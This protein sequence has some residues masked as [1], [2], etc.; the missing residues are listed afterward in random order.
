MA[1]KAQ[2]P[3]EIRFPELSG[4]DEVSLR[5]AAI[6]ESSDDAIISKDL[7]G[8]VRSWNRAAT[9]LFGWEPDE[10]IGRSILTIIPPE[11]HHEE[12]E[13]LRKLR[14]GERIEHYETVRIRKDGTRR[15]FSLTISPL[16]M[17]DGRIV[18]AS[19]IARDI[20]ERKRS[21]EIRLRLAAIVDSSED[22]II[23]KDLNGIVRS[24]NPAATRMFGWQPEEIIGKSILALIPEFLHDEEVEI[25]QQLR[26][27]RHIEHYE[28]K[29]LHRSGRLLDVSLTVS[30]MKDL[31]GR[32]IGA[33]KIA[34][35]ISDRKRMQQALID[36]EK[37]AATGRMAAAI[38]HE[39]NNPL[40]AVTNLAYLLTVDATLNETAQR[41]AKLLL[42]EIG[43]ASAITKQ[44]L[45][46][47]RD[48][49]K[50]SDVHM[51][52]LLDDV[53]EINR[54]RLCEKDIEIRREYQTEDLLFGYESELRQVFANLVLN[55]VDAMRPRGILRIRVSKDPSRNGAASRIRVSVGDN[56]SGM[57]SASRLKLFEPFY[58][59]KGS[60]GNG[61]GLWI[62]RGIVEKH[63]GKI[64]VWSRSGCIDSGTVFSV[65]LP[66]FDQERREKVAV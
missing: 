26:N 53:L 66:Q 8:I 52:K 56:G 48:T 28:T 14:N 3:D 42:Q 22:A 5:L 57:S 33:S 18:G 63:G 46:F 4:A 51:R 13:I 17:A 30:P 20:T 15:D 54:H 35:D 7:N 16:K 10:M 27:G 19:K 24:W 12:A 40:E 49:G 38:A 23:S 44:T 61:L 37:L 59:T 6:V 34:R 50:P 45:G 55:A 2:S 32:V 41:Y 47:Y 11:L 9:R 25:L 39:I 65:L 62:S 60:S 31:N 43:R 64:K 21:D 58:T 1:G 29:R 36:S